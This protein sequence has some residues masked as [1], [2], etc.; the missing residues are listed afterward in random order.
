M[1]RLGA[2][3]ER[4]ALRR[5]LEIRQDGG[6]EEQRR[7]LCAGIEAYLNDLRL[8]PANERDLIVRDWENKISADRRTL[9]REL[10]S[11]NL[12]ALVEKEGLVAIF[13][14]GVAG[15]TGGATAGFALGARSAL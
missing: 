3:R 12:E 15:A 1:S 10:R 6:F 9:I 2:A 11:A 7:T 14:G 13:L 8:T 4:A 5:L